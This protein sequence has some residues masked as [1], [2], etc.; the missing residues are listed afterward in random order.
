LRLLDRYIFKE[1]FFACLAGVGFFTFVVMTANVL[2]D[3]LSF[4]LAGQL[5]VESSV[6]LIL[7]LVPPA[8]MYALP[9]GIL[10]GV[11]VVLGRLSAESEIIAM[12]ACGLSLFR[13]CLP[14]YVFAGVGAA[15]ALV[16]N[17]YWMPRARVIYHE[18]LA[19]IV[20]TNPVKILVPKTFIRD[21]PGIVIYV[22]ERKGPQLKDFWLWELDG[23][24]RVTALSHAE[25]GRID[26]DEDRNEIVFTPLNGWREPRNRKD[27]EDFSKP[28]GS[29]GVEK[30]PFRL[31]LERLFGKRTVQTKTDWLTWSELRSK[32]NH[33][34]EPSTSAG[35]ATRTRDRM[36]LQ[37]VIQDK[38]T[39]A[40]AVI[41]FALVAVPLGIKVSRRETSANL[42][43]AL[44]L[45][46]AYYFLTV[47][48]KWMDNRPE[49][50][51]DLWLWGPN[52]VFLAIGFWL[53][54]RAAQT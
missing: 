39:T 24:Q 33:L 9:M 32:I 54:R 21:F 30:V 48:V 52:I 18:E 41:T 46:L 4:I 42:G 45:T 38:L 17:F 51:P 28:L 31:P 3:L 19:N 22:N 40:F 26:F 44:I 20:R 2:K 6:K 5:P 47:V 12:R 27:P 1:V 50:R 7:Y 13:I 16:V 34:S 11:L 8:A 14:V 37:I 29:E 49:L 43:V 10:C 53:N 36:K 35:E 23:E 15:C 25:S